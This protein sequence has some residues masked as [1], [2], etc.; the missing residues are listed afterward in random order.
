M[1][2]VR[3]FS[4]NLLKEFIELYKSLPCLWKIGSKDYVDRNK[5][6]DAYELLADKLREVDPTA[7]RN[8]VVRRINSLRSSWR[9]EMKKVAAS[10]NC[11]DVY[12]PRLWYFEL[13]TFLNTQKNPNT[14]ETINKTL[15]SNNLIDFLFLEWNFK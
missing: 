13:F 9:K 7:D 4:R 15:V 5:K 12:K 2:D 8:T 3:Y 10:K 11:E 1:G 14:F 6:S